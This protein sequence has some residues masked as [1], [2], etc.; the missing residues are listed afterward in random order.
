[1][2]RY[3]YLVGKLSQMILLPVRGIVINKI[4]NVSPKW[5]IGFWLIYSLQIY[6]Y[7]AQAQVPGK[8]WDKRFGGDDSD[9]LS[10]VVQLKDGGYLLAGESSS[11]ISGD[12]TESR[13]ETGFY[14]VSYIY[15]Y[16]I[17][18]TDKNG[19]K[20]WDKRF[21]GGNNDELITVIHTSDGS[22]LLAG[23]SRSDIGGDK[24][25]VSR[26]D[27]DY[28]IV[29]IDSAGNKLWD[30]TYGGSDSD[31]LKSAI[32]TKDGGFLLAGTLQ[33]YE[34]SSDYRIVKI[35]STGNKLWDKTFGGIDGDNL[36]T[37]TQ[38]SDGGYLLAGNSSSAAGGD[39]TEDSK[40]YSDYWIVKIDST[41]NKLWDKTFGGYS[42]DYLTAAIQTK[43]D[44]FLLAGYSESGISGDKTQPSR[45]S[46]DFWILKT[47]LDSV[48]SSPLQIN[49]QNRNTKTPAGWVK[50]YGLPFG[51]KVQA[52]SDSV[53]RYGWK[54]REDG[55]PIDLSVGGPFPGNGRWRP[56]PA[57]PLLATLMHMQGN[58]VKNFRGTPVEAYW[59][60][61]V[62]NGDYQVGIS[63]GDGAEYTSTDP[64][65]HSINIEGVAI[66]KNFIPQGF[67]GRN[68][69]F[70]Q[71]TVQVTVT[72]GLLT[73]DADG[74]VNTKINFVVI[75]PLKAFSI[76]N[77]RGNPPSQAS[78]STSSKVYPNPFEE[79][80]TIQTNFR[81][82][83]NIELIDLLGN[84]S[85][86]ATYQL[87]TN[88]IEL[89]LSQVPMKSGMYLVKLQ[90]EDGTIQLIKIFKR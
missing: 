48:V 12:K 67:S 1:M 6:N 77:T 39:K 72:D 27:T 50:D 11:D 54:K 31:Y 61:A 8:Q 82:K 89:E 85:Y 84:M 42:Y 41:G 49:F 63:V 51:E 52:R 40:F 86:K 62:E 20:Q 30:K 71:E 9:R 13:R 81:G 79:E 60:L 68:T 5:W 3:L 22:S 21:G 47:T 55:T 46:K 90:G 44:N 58:H 64:E 78:I 10:S 28:W 76:A 16:W 70:K 34:K 53:Y 38:T 32:Q 69:R 45:G 75:Q 26:G 59:E 36:T 15:D 88:E 18:K 73:I 4:S 37:A 33:S 56:A 66:I 2:Q 87:Q 19:I 7:I 74:G 17:T 14:K 29:K 25:E 65:S 24:T 43:D 83:V 80:V 23:S 57:D 35:D